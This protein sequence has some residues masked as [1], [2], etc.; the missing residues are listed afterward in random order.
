MQ[1]RTTRTVA[2]VENTS[3]L[4]FIPTVIDRGPCEMHG[5]STGVPCFHIRGDRGYLPA[6]CNRRA[7]AAGM[8]SEISQNAFTVKSVS[9]SKKRS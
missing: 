8:N 4:K 6:I 9:K 5:V 2:P 1:Y 3:H 7:R